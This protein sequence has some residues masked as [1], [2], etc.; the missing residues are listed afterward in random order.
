MNHVNRRSYQ[1][2]YNSLAYL[3]CKYQKTK[4]TYKSRSC[5]IIMTISIGKH[6]KANLY[7]TYPHSLKSLV[8]LSFVS[9]SFYSR[10]VG[11]ERFMSNYV[12]TGCISISYSRHLNLSSEIVFFLHQIF[13]F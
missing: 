3:G 9:F 2:V 4:S 5:A 11:P 6:F 10:P 13:K 7:Y 8:F 1:H 12:F